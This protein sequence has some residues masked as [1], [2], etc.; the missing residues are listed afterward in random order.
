MTRAFHWHR[1]GVVACLASLG[2]GSAWALDPT[3]PPA[4]LRAVAP[5]AASASAAPTDRPRLQGLR[6]GADPSALINGRVLRPGQR[7]QGHT[8]LRIE[9]DSAVLRDPEGR[10]LRLHLLTPPSPAML[11]ASGVRP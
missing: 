1:A 4:A 6:L 5:V 9:V 3:Q 11:P 2:L 8:L 7:W 10:S